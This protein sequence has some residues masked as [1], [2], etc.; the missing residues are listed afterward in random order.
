MDEFSPFKIRKDF[1]M[2]ALGSLTE[3]QIL[4]WSELYE[5]LTASAF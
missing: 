4:T 2:T 1:D 5:A 3:M